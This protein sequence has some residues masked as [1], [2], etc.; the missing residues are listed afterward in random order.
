MLL[1]ITDYAKKSKCTPANIRTRL[2]NKVI[3][4]KKKKLPD[5]SWGEYI[6]TR[7][8]PPTRMRKAGG[9]RKSKED[10]KKK[11]VN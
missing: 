5:G 9:G 11:K 10:T 7:K 6:D 8:F 2:K 3:K 4:L 1:T